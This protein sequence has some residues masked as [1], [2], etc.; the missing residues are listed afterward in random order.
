[1]SKK[2]QTELHVL[3]PGETGWELWKRVAE[4]G[5]ERVGESGP[6]KVGEMGSLPG[7]ELAMFFPVRAY[8]ALPFRAA[9]TDETLFEDLATMHAERL[10]VRAD[11]LAGQLSDTFKV[12]ADEESTVLLHVVLQ[13]PGEGELPARTPKEF[14][15]S[16]RALVVEGDAVAVWRELGR[17]VFA[18]HVEGRLLYSQATASAEAA[19]GAAVVREI[20]LA[21]GQLALQGLRVKPDRVL[22][23][24]DAPAA[25]AGIGSSLGPM[26]ETVAKPAP[27]MPSPLSR[28]LPEDVRAARL[29][30]RKEQQRA[31][32]IG[33][34]AA[35]YLGVVGWFAFQVWQ[36]FRTRNELAREAA[37]VEGVSLAFQEH[38]ARWLE[39]GPVVD[40]QRSPLEIM[41]HVANSI[42]PNS[43]LRLSTADVGLEQIK[44]TGAAPQSQPVNAFS[45]AL[46]RNADLS[47][48]EWDN[49]APSNSAKGWEFIF[50][51][52]PI[53]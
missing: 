33:L 27:A 22:V 48:L 19:P 37:E 35:I 30:R 25:S 28:L 49:T 36:D 3:V 45:L 39:L 29:Q 42:P 47:W 34:A 10:G 44:I 9:T 6:L 50:T 41:L 12:G 43:G 26:A 53:P 18:I 14:D 38:Q 16:P 20:R 17:W 1:M 2:K 4:D 13:K 21:L 15:L 51:G 31:A 8:Q 46:K 40:E 52:N 32:L 24:S 11:P 23:F 5:F 7:G